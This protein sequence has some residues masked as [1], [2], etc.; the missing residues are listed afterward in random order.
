[1]RALACQNPEFSRLNMRAGTADNS[2]PVDAPHARSLTP[3]L[4]VLEAS[5]ASNCV[6]PF[7]YR[8]VS[9]SIA[10]TATR[11]QL[12]PV[13]PYKTRH[14]G[15]STNRGRG[16]RPLP[17]CQKRGREVSH[18]SVVRYRKAARLRARWHQLALMCERD[19]ASS[20]YG[21]KRPPAGCRRRQ[22]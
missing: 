21:D 7:S 14:S 18:K 16:V 17:E 11:L 4:Q 2:I 8:D 3:A 1:M 6:W 12:R 9:E 19:F 13:V 22:T 10:S 20:S 5:N 15:P